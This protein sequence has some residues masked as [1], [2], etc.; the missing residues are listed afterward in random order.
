MRRA[1]ALTR[2]LATITAASFPENCSASPGLG[3]ELSKQYKSDLYREL[4]PLLNS[5]N[6]VLPKHDK[7]FNQIVGLER[8]V[9]RGGHD[10]I[11][12]RRTGATTTSQM[13][14]PALLFWR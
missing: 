4:L 7:L 14:L 13:L 9:A 5:K 1:I 3:Y 12:H 8:K 6:I 10:S 2:L 11:D